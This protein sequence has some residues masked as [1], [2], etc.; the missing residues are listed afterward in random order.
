[1]CR[2]LGIFLDQYLSGEQTEV[3]LGFVWLIFVSLLSYVCMIH[4]CVYIFATHLPLQVYIF[5]Y[6]LHSDRPEESLALFLPIWLCIGICRSQLC[7]YPKVLSVSTL[8]PQL[9]RQGVDGSVYTLAR[10]A[11]GL[12]CPVHLLLHP[13][14]VVFLT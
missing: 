11:S 5:V 12:A 1:M 9:F 8:W 7:L 13:L 4:L 3:R 6:N 2:H 10:V 14:G